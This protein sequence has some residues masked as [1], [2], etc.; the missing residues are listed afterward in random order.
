M[1]YLGTN[2]LEVVTGTVRAEL[3]RAPAAAAP[4]KQRGGCTGQ[5]G[6]GITQYE[7]FAGVGTVMHQHLL[8]QTEP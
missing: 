6:T 2:M 3:S 5:P 4:C 8:V 1:L 7:L